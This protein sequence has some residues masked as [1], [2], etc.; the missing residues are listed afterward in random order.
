MTEP[1]RSDELTQRYREASAQDA[2]RPGA[3]VRDAVRAH[4]QMVIEAGRQIPATGSGAPTPPPANQSR[5]KISAL[6]SLALAGLT[7]LL[8][9]QFDRGTDEEKDLAFGQPSASAPPAAAT[10]PTAPAAA[11]AV[12]S[13]APQA[14][15]RSAKA[16]QA[17][18]PLPAPKAP[19]APAAPAAKKSTAPP[20][21]SG[22]TAPKAEAEAA[23]PPPPSP[24]PSPAAPPPAAPEIAAAQENLLFER[25]AR[26][27]ETVMGGQ[28]ASAAPVPQ[29]APAAPAAAAVQRSA[30]M[31]APSAAAPAAAPPEE[32][33][34]R[35][36]APA[37]VLRKE[38]PGIP[39]LAGA[40]QNAARAGNLPQVERLLQQ[41][42][43]LN[44]ADAEG[45]TPLIL[46]AMQGHTAV[47]QRLLAAGANT[48]LIDHD[49]LNALQ[50]ARR[51]GYD[52]IAHLIEAAR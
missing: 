43:A 12:T 28:A 34:E 13:Q 41:G 40:L 24:A 33:R 21:L 52:G 23:R 9:L 27:S 2:R 8:V 44:A 6:A 14:D 38:A 29:A 4:A 39:K 19:P 45:R 42:A 25:S 3:H 46:A 16:R 26:Q 22:S 1:D 37:S 10:A 32:K 35:Q 48:A 11:D 18:S 51:L 5:W 17:E 15:S 31:A 7:G 36:S 47:V 49:G 20:S 30:P 50:H